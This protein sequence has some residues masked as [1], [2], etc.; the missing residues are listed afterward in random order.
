M[1]ATPSVAPSGTPGGG[2]AA[3]RSPRD[4]VAPLKPKSVSEM[5]ALYQNTQHLDQTGY[6]HFAE[7]SHV[8]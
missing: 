4:L 7:A 1:T 2:S 5:L 3:E 6:R 8:H